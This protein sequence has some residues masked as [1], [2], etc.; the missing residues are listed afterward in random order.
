[1]GPPTKDGFFYDFYSP[2]SRVVHEADY[3]LLEKEVKDIVKS[4]LRFERLILTK[5]EALELFEY[6]RFKTYLIKTKVPEGA[7]TSVYKI[8]DFIDLCTG[9]HLQHT[10]HVKGF[11]ITKHSASYWLGDAKKD[12]LQ[13]IYGVAF[14]EKSMLEEFLK[15]REEA[16]LR[17][18]RVIG[19]N[20][21]LYFF[22]KLAPG[23]AFFL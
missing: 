10:G 8:G 18:H 3:P 1:V 23:S 14:P 6:N 16:K 22:H 12:H 2:H 15:Q 17:D 4:R 5:E 7:L 20:Q 21:S 19:Q 9:P 11:A 13:R